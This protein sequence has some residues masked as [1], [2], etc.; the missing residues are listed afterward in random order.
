MTQLMPKWF[1]ITACIGAASV[2]LYFSWAREF[3]AIDRCLDE[4]GRYEERSQ[5]CD[6]TG[7]ERPEKP[8]A[9]HQTH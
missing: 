8:P 5:T 2:A 7:T 6:K 9:L 3:I 4:G 1:L